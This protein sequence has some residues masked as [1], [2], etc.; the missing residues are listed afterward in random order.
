MKR[1]RFIKLLMANGIPGACERLPPK[2]ARARAQDVILRHRKYDKK[3]LPYWE[4]I[5]REFNKITFADYG[6][7]YFFLTHLKPCIK[8]L[9]E[10]NYGPSDND[11]Q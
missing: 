8:G 2:I 6:T 4:A 10:I 1:K 9:V 5:H 3:D 7:Y 11:S